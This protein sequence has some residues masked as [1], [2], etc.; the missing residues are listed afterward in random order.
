MIAS[1]WVGN[2]V[3]P[4]KTVAADEW[5]DPLAQSNRGLLVEIL[6]GPYFEYSR[7]RS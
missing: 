2:T 7:F 6:H 5:P 4:W 3:K 1:R